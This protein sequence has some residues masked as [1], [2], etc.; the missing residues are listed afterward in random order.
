VYCTGFYTGFKKEAAAVLTRVADLVSSLKKFSH[1]LVIQL[2]ECV[3]DFLCRGRPLKALSKTRILLVGLA[4]T[5]PI[6]KAY[7]N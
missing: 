3:P 1:A 7:G 4:T 5:T 6:W 2:D